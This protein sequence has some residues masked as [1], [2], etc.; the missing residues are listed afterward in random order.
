ML[1]MI[2]YVYWVQGLFYKRVFHALNS[3]PG[4]KPI[5]A[6]EAADLGVKPPIVTLL[7]HHPDKV[8]SNGL[9]V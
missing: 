4:K 9:C 3:K 7:N 1:K 2:L 6:R 8:T 5:M